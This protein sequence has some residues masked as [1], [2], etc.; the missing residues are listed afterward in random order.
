[1]LLHHW[2]QPS[3][4]CTSPILQPTQNG[5]R[6]HTTAPPTHNRVGENGTNAPSS[7]IGVGRASIVRS[8]PVKIDSL[9]CRDPSAKGQV[10]VYTQIAVVST[11]RTRGRALA[12]ARAAFDAVPNAA[13]HVLDLDGSYV[14]ESH[15]HVVRPDDV[16]LDA[17]EHHVRTVLL[18]P[19]D[20]V[21]WTQ[22]ALLRHALLAGPGVLAVTA[23]MLLL[24]DPSELLELA[25]PDGACLIARVTAA[26]PADGA[27]P[28]RAD[29]LAAGSYSPGLIAVGRG[30]TEFLDLWEQLAC[31]PATASD[32]WLDAAASRLALRTVRAASCLVSP[33]TAP[34]AQIGAG[35][36]GRLEVDGVR[37]LAVDFTGI[38][39]DSPWLLDAH[40]DAP[41]RLRLSAH[42]PLARLAAT[43]AHHLRRDEGQQP[44]ADQ[45]TSLGATIHPQ[46]RDVFR[47]A[48]DEVA[49]PRS[50]DALPDP[51]DADRAG[52]LA[53]WLVVPREDGRDLGLGR[54]LESV[55]RSRTDL[56]K[57][58]PG[59]PGQDVPA[60]L[61]WTNLHGRNEAPYSAVLI[62][63]ALA[64]ITP[65]LSTAPGPR[66]GRRPGVNV[67]GYLRGEL[68][69]GE[70]A[71]LM[72]GA[73]TASGI[74]HATATVDRDL[75]SR[76]SATYASG[77]TGAAFDTTL[78]CVNADS[79]P[80]VAASMPSL[81]EHSYRIGM[82]YWE[83]E[84]FPA[85]QHVGFKHV[86]EVWVATDFVRR[87]IEPHSPVPVRTVTP[88]LP[89]PGAAPSRTRADL[90]LTERPYFLFSFDYLSTAERKNPWGLVDAF[91]AAFAPGAG[92][93]LVIKSINADRR[94]AQAERLRLR[95][96]GSTD[97]LLLEEYLPVADRDALVLLCECY[98]S[99]H[100]SEGLGLTMAEAMAL[101]KPVIATGYS[102]NLQF[103][104]EANSFLV[105]WT[106][107][108]IGPGSEPYPPGCIWAE[109]DVQVAAELMRTVHTNP[110]LAAARGARAADDLATLH[111]PEVAGRRIAARLAELAP[112]RQARR[113][114]GGRDQA[115]AIA[116]RALRR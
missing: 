26:I 59:V 43:F 18:A 115:L 112:V 83:V 22:P 86:D 93:L 99:L 11:S 72:L 39:P 14:R 104:T 67:I 89:R 25:G 35:A 78:L 20:V 65:G 10:L 90:G 56:Q 2:R 61:E 106:P 98:V 47:S 102:G 3:S 107:A 52:E 81:L 71:R 42:P 84:D 110:A 68:G 9:G 5:R 62:D 33:W 8:A 13:V 44:P 113:R 74:E 48:L 70:S 80:A 108:A 24:R 97:I 7:T 53:A 109:P 49:G 63:L 101:G 75:Q 58:Y 77:A 60:F 69:I 87:A 45:V 66:R 105:P 64:A 95:I 111:S 50:T 32:R 36:D 41:P 92:P 54:Y 82:W 40:A 79:T 21:R 88:P 91:E 17:R 31:D 73:L 28:S 19:G 37:P 29:L 57:R 34:S 103:M 1:M 94:P 114:S 27:W 38:D 76:Q 12:S 46:L 116:R 55:Y 96:G 85:S 16:G 4:A 30:A 15:E 6:P 100:R 51:L 23:G